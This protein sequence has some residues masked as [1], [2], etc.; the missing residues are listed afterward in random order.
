MPN[1]GILEYF[2]VLSSSPEEREWRVEMLIK[3]KT[4]EGTTDTRIALT[5]LATALLG[6]KE[7]MVPPLYEVWPVEVEVEKDQ[8]QS[9]YVYQNSQENQKVSKVCLYCDQPKQVILPY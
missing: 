4:I 7:K 3:G 2:K 8:Q 9:I 1:P 5:V 6:R